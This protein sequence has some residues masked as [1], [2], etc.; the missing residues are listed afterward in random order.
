MSEGGV[1]TWK[2]KGGGLQVAR[3]ACRRVGLARACLI[4]GC[5]RWKSERSFEAVVESR[6]QKGQ[7]KMLRFTGNG[8]HG[9]VVSGR[10]F[11]P[12][13]SCSCQSQKLY[14]LPS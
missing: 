13:R 9:T 6:K 12:G 7:S 14:F 11:L 4:C 1:G 2:E 8:N 5:G 10:A 3:I